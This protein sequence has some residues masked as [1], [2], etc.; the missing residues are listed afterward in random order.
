MVGHAG[1]MADVAR[2][3][4]D[5]GY[6]VIDTATTAE[7]DLEHVDVALVLT[8]EVGPPGVVTVVAGA[9]DAL[10][11]TPPADAYDVLV[12]PARPVEVLSRVAAALHTARLMRVD[13]LTGLPDRRHVEEH[14]TMAASAARRQ[15]QPFS[16]LLLDVDQLARVEGGADAVMSTVARRV[17]RRLRGEDLAGRWGPDE[18]LIVLPATDID[19]AWTLAERIRTAVFDEPVS[20]P[21][22]GDALVTV[23]IG[24]AQSDGGDVEDVLRRT[25]AALIE[26]KSLGRNRV[27]ADT[28][29]AA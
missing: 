9:P 15:R 8:G 17:Q 1:A 21:G 13:P 16:V 12:L 14:V 2:L 10:G 26:A 3:L 20:L 28:A 25:E 4:V 29:T 11:E 18:L 5:A 19:G 22:G 27:V 6:D 24:C 7:D 23:S